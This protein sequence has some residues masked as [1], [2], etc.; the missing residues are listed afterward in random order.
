ML[1][2]ADMTGFLWLVF[3]LLLSIAFVGE[4]VNR[5]SIV[6]CYDIHKIK[7]CNVCLLRTGSI[8]TSVGILI[9]NR[10][11][12]YILYGGFSK[13][14]DFSRRKQNYSTG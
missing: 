13:S 12:R 3:M 11:W 1:S 4:R 9:A 7:L 10:D 6:F 5:I 14:C 2:Y 8:L